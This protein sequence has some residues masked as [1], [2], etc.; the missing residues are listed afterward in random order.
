MKDNDNP[1]RDMVRSLSDTG[2]EENKPDVIDLTRNKLEN[3]LMIR[4]LRKRNTELE[5]ALKENRHKSIDS[6]TDVFNEC[7]EESGQVELL[8]EMLN[9]IINVL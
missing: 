2:R 3:E 7:I 6:I 9:K 1:Y 4:D 5:S 8:G